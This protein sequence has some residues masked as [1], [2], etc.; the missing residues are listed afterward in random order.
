[1]YGAIQKSIT[2][3]I[4]ENIIFLEEIFGNNANQ[5]IPAVP[6]LE[7][8][9]CFQQTP[10]KPLQNYRQRSKDWPLWK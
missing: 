5:D 3:K 4:L 1:M 10:P 7:L 8:A 6:V 2:G 9:R